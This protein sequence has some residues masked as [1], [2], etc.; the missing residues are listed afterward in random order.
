MNMMKRVLMTAALVAGFAFSSEA[1][2][3][4]TYTGQL[5]KNATSLSV[6]SSV[7]TKKVTLVRK[8]EDG[9]NYKYLRYY[10]MTLKKGNAYTV[11]LTGDDATN[12]A[13]RIR[14]CYGKSTLD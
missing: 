10:K 13:V 5:E 4:P 14:A 3:D 9:K 8:T 12:G 6:S 1:K 11:W 7:K 2:T